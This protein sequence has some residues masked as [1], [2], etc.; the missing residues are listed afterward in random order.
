MKEQP[1]HIKA[2]EYY[3]AL[4][5]N[6]SYPKVARK[7]TVSHTSVKKWAKAFNWQDRVADRDKKNAITVA[8]KVDEKTTDRDARNIKIAEGAISVFAKSLIGY[9]EHKCECGAVVQIPIPKAKITADQFDKMVRLVGHIMGEEEVKGGTT[10]NVNL[11]QCDPAPR[12]VESRV[13]E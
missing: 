4:E 13:V 10:I 12:P 5:D 2:F 1:R 7:F 6:R 3:V 8:K 9:I 11:I